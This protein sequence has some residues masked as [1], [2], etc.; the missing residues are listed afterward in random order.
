[1]YLPKSKADKRR[2]LLG[3]SEGSDTSEIQRS[4]LGN[5]EG[6]DTGEILKEVIP[7]PLNSLVCQLLFNVRGLRV[8]NKATHP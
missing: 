6:S 3:N 8:A 2:S 1:M 4:L 7:L 5:S